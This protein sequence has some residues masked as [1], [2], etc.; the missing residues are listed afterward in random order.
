MNNNN[1]PP[2]PELLCALDAIV[3]N[4]EPALH[5][6]LTNGN[7]IP[8]QEFIAQWFELLEVNNSYAQHLD[9]VATFMDNEGVFD[10]HS[11]ML[12]AVQLGRISM[13]RIM[14]E[15]Y[16]LPWPQDIATIAAWADQFQTYRY[17]TS[18]SDVDLTHHDYEEDIE[19]FQNNPVALEY[20]NN[21]Q[22]FDIAQLNVKGD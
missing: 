19:H 13:I 16:H 21:L 18:E 20:I 3:N 1:P 5:H 4:N 15:Q 14:R 2:T 9:R 6:F 7:L 17:L 10:A 22:T 11:P 12:L 8:S